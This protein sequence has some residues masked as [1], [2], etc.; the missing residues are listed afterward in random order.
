[1]VLCAHSSLAGHRNRCTVLQKNPTP[2][3][4]N[5]P[6][7]PLE[8]IHCDL[9]ERSYP[10]GVIAMRGRLNFCEMCSRDRAAECLSLLNGGQKQPQRG[11]RTPL[12]VGGAVAVLI[13]AAGVGVWVKF[14]GSTTKQTADQ[15]ATPVPTV[16]GQPLATPAPA[17]EVA[18]KSSSPAT[19]TDEKETASK[20]KEE[21]EA[22]ARNKRS[23]A[24]AGQIHLLFVSRPGTDSQSGL[25]S[26]LFVTREEPNPESAKLMTKVGDH[27][28]TSFDEGLR[29]V[30]KQSRKWESEFS[31]RLSFED[32]FTEKDGG[33][34][35]TG[36][37]IAMLA[38]IEDAALD[39]AVAITGDLTIDGTVQPVG[40]VVDKLRGAIEGKCRITLIPER[41]SRDLVD[42]ALLD[43]TSSLWETQVLTI[44]TVDQAL[45]TARQQRADDLQSALDRFTALRARLPAT[46]TPNYLQAPIVQSELKEI[47]RLAPNHLSAATLLKAAENQLPKELSLNRSVEEILFASYLF[48]NEVLNPAPATTSANANAS[49][50][51]GPGITVFPE[52]EYNACLKNLQRLT[53]IL[54]K[55]SMEL[56]ASCVTYT[57]TLRSVWTY[58]PAQ[59]TNTKWNTQAEEFV[60]REL[61]FIRQAQ[62]DWKDARSNLLLALR[63][64]DTDGSLMAEIRKK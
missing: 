49:S 20:E 63:K 30:R 11:S 38:A 24:D 50:N 39:P 34:A 15:A 28:K 27:M 57:G 32:K 18:A 12:M 35:G 25:S 14:A 64:L 59:N 51:R 56:K 2:M 5:A 62:D 33:S 61:R 40:G 3:P 10:S 13:L 4:E 9:C 47:L 37:T 55:R 6:V 7:P 23:V 45:A 26:R 31:I 48:V 52:R 21:K 53:P 1:M 16:E 43:G 36:F 42:L 46:V 22:A 44:G 19:A 54:D 17:K 41:N 29:Y 8:F 60:R 58:R